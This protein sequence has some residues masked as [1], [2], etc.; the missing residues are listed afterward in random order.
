MTR[1]GMSLIARRFPLIAPSWL[2]LLLAHTRRKIDVY[3]IRAFPGQDSRSGDGSP[4]PARAVRCP[5]LWGAVWL[6]RVSGGGWA[7][8]LLMASPAAFRARRLF[9]SANALS[10]AL[11]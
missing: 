4:G 6:I 10:H 9:V 7:L 2:S 11:T 3:D 1:P 8:L 5:G